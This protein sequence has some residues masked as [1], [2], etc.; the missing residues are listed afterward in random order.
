[1]RGPLLRA[2]ERLAPHRL[3]G[4]TDHYSGEAAEHLLMAFMFHRVPLAWPTD[5]VLAWVGDD[6]RRGQRAVV[7]VRPHA[8]A[9]DP[10]LRALV[11]RFGSRSAVANAILS[12]MHSTD[13]MVGSLAEHD[14]RQLEHARPWLVDPDP[15]V[16]AFA[17]RAVES[18]QI[19][20]EQHAAYE[21]DRQRRFGT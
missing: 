1:L 3:N 14:A 8:D 2:L 6:E 20:Y 17:K 9:L 5:E 11:R 19:S 13:G 7:L 21:E 10:V 18:L 12:R 4:L 16:S 15:N